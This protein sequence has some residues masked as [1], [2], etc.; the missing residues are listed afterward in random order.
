MG[1]FFLKFIYGK[2]IIKFKVIF[3]EFYLFMYF[4]FKEIFRIFIKLLF[5]VIFRWLDWGRFFFFIVF[6][7]II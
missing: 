7:C 5:M 2:M 1:I 4:I 6:M 3:F